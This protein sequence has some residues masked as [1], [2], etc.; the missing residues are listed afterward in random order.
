MANFKE[1]MG[2][3]LSLNQILCLLDKKLNQTEEDECYIFAKGSII[4]GYEANVNDKHTGSHEEVAIA[5]ITVV[6]VKK[7]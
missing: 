3:W 4:L 1:T 6:L 5:Q 7:N 2:F